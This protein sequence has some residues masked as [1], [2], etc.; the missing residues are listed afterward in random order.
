MRRVNYKNDGVSMEP[1]GNQIIKL[2]ALLVDQIAAGEVVERPSSVVKELVENSL[3]AGSSLIDVE[4][5]DGGKRLIQVTDDGQGI[6]PTQLPLAL[7]SHATSKLKVA[8]DLHRILTLGFRG[9][10]LAS[11]ASVA[12]VEIASRTIKE[13]VAHRVH[14]SDGKIESQSPVAMRPG[15]RVSVK[16]LFS[17]VPARRRFLKASS[18]EVARCSAALK[19]AALAHPTVGFSLTH[20]GRTVLKYPADQSLLERIS[21]VLGS[22]VG[23]RMISVS[24]DDG[25]SGWVARPDLQRR[26]GDG[27]W[28][29]LNGR[30]LRDRVL[31]HA[32]R[33][34]FRGFQ[35]PGQYP[36]AVVGVE[37]DPAEVDVNVHPSKL[38]VRFRDREGVHR[39]IR[40]AIRSALETAGSVPNLPLEDS[41]LPDLIPA[42]GQIAVA[43]AGVSA[44]RVV[45]RVASYGDPL[46]TGDPLSAGDSSTSG[47]REALVE[48]PNLVSDSV[49]VFQVRDSFL[50]LE[51]SD[52]LRV[53]DQHALHE[54]ILY[55]K[56]LAAR[57]QGT[58]CQ[59]L[60]VPE[61]VPLD[62]DQWSLFVEYKQALTELGLE[63]DEFGDGVALVRAVPQGFE[64]SDPADLLREVLVKFE[65]VR[66]FG[67][68]PPDLR[69]RLLQTMA[70]KAAVKAG[71]PLSPEAQEDLVKGREQAFQPWNCPHG[72]PSE[73]FISWQELERRFDRK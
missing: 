58:L 64:S 44:D 55:E 27:I 29:F 67:A 23:T 18:A 12:T 26:N 49:R 36:I 72:R 38:E 30:P 54:K 50:V 43:S 14:G 6:E 24:S 22:D 19:G 53:I 59:G 10:A 69:E 68:A 73:L 62:P 28:T 47:S 17:A 37:L 11:I 40:R 20:D 65:S 15:T 42:A 48:R 16:D 35:I 8:E 61:P 51:E 33:E 71:Q 13:D 9:E 70:C 32:V 41:A 21:E 39:R 25:V 45:E 7:E 2:P 3:D 56:I 63:A 66:S 1:S 31:Q 46:A 57:E 5:Q 52:G 4:L 34:G 60:L